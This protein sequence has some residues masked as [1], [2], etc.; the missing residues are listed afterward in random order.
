MIRSED[1]RGPQHVAESDRGDWRRPDR[2]PVEPCGRVAT[3]TVMGVATLAI[4]A[5]LVAGFPYTSLGGTDWGA[6]L[7]ATSRRAARGWLA[8][9]STFPRQLHGPYPIEL[10]ECSTRRGAL[11]VHPVPG[12]PLPALV[13]PGSRA[14]RL[15][16][17]VVAAGAVGGRIDLAAWHFRIGGPLLPMCSVVVFAALVAAALRWKW[18][19]ALIVLKPSS[20]RSH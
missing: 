20:C 5:Q 14:P 15:R 4:V 2:R 8:A 11:P 9:A 17:L 13:G 12:A 7:V 16:R 18:P 10:R 19:G 1:V 6:D 3:L